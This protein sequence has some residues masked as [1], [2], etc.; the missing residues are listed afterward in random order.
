MAPPGRIAQYMGLAQMPWL[1]AKGTTG[2]Y[3][4]FLL[5]KFCPPHTPAAELHTGKLWLIYA[6]IGM[7]SPI[8]LW[9]ARKWVRAGLQTTPG[10]AVEGTSP[11]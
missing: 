11:A 6:C 4:G 5:A 9:M 1:L 8:G 3:S 2:F 7:L 10:K